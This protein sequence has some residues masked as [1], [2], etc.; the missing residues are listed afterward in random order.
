MK[1]PWTKATEN[2][3]DSS[4]TDALIASLIRQVRGRTAGAALT[5]ET[6]ALE[7]GGGP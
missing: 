2:Y 3:A 1:L 5:S 4:Y 7:S 6:G